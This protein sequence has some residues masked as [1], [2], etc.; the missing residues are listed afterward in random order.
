M[1]CAVFANGM[2]IACKAAD[3]KTIAAM[4][5][6]CLSPPT[7]PAGPIPVPYP[8]TAM[9]SD[10][11][12]GSKT[13]QI[14][15]QEVMLK[16]K[17]TFKKSTGDE[18]ATKSLGMGVV[19]HQIQGKVSFVAWSMDVKFEG[20]N[21]PRH[22]DLTLHNEMSVPSNT[23]PWPYIDAMAVPLDHP[24]KK[25][26][27]RE[28]R[29]CKGVKN[30][31]NQAGALKK[32]CGLKKSRQASNM[33]DRTAANKCLAARRCKLQPYDRDKTKCCKGQTPHHLV[34][35]SA[36]FDSGRGGS[37]SVPLKGITGYREGDAPCVCVEG[38]N[39]N[40]GTHG[41]MHTFQST[42]AS[43][44]ASGKLRL[45]NGDSIAAKKTTFSAA[46]M[47]GVKCMKKVFPESKCSPKCIE[48]QLDEYHKQSGV[49]DETPVKAVETG[50]ST[51]EAAKAA[52]QEIADRSASVVSGRGTGANTMY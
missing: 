18:A 52:N 14:G 21:V 40:T 33:A 25:D 42:I 38:I 30:P 39:Q 8:N 4:P 19:A 5:D 34:E 43:K 49:D 37:T 9:A 3:G 11:A 6:V 27:K 23:G 50:S 51:R 16:D 20:E 17:S 36:F 41:L 15:G 47:S 24:C 44:C 22:L 48:A 31:C 35:A 29:A 1:G 12:D 26:A 28:E 2:S 46:K 32:P 45:S 10:T 7:P 13:V